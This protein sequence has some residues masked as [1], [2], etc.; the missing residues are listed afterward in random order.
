M[1]ISL[2]KLKNTTL[3]ALAE[4]IVSASKNGKF[5]ITVTNHPLLNAVETENESYKQLINKQTYSGK[6]REVAKA[7]ETRDRLFNAI[8]AYLKGFVGLE[9]LPNHKDAVVLYEVF[10]KNDFNL[11]KKSYA[12]QSVL[13][14]K[15]LVDLELAENKTK[16][17]NLNLTEALAELKSAQRIFSQ[18]L[19]EQTEAN[20]ELRLTQSAS[21]VR[22]SL[23]TAIRDYLNFVSAMR[24]LPEWNS[25]YTELSEV[26]KEIR[27]S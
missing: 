13:L 15:L 16:A 21:S 12:D 11:D 25:L 5:T 19:S 8:K 4:R 3:A 14:D 2:K 24:S 23:E 18:L 6:G 22:K 26:V 10:R 17:D 9:L 20:T 27:N 1:K 7:D